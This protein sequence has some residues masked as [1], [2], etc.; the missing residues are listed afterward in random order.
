MELMKLEC[1]FES[2]VMSP[3]VAYTV[4]LMSAK[5]TPTIK[6][7]NLKYQK[8]SAKGMRKQPAATI[9][10]A[11]SMEFFKPN[12]GRKEASKNEAMAIGKSLN[13]SRTLAADFVTSK[14]NCICKMT[15]PTLFEQNSENEII[16]KKGNLDA[17][18]FHVVLM[19]FAEQF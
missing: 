1:S 4:T 11:A 12:F 3:M 16:E 10:S 17:C 13:P 18:V 19:L 7:N 15:A 9:A 2:L 8:S 14:F 5:E 6:N